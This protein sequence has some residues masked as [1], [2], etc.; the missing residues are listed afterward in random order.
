L[1]NYFFRPKNDADRNLPVGFQFGLAEEY[2][3]WILPLLPHNVE[4][5]HIDPIYYLPLGVNVINTSVLV[6]N[7]L[8]TVKKV[9]CI[10]AIPQLHPYQNVTLDCSIISVSPYNNYWNEFS[11]SDPIAM[12]DPHVF[13]RISSLDAVL[14]LV[15][16]NEFKVHEY[17]DDIVEATFKGYF[18]SRA[19]DNNTQF[20][21]TI[22][23]D[24][25]MDSPPYPVLS[26]ENIKLIILTHGLKEPKDRFTREL[27]KRTIHTGFGRSSV[28]TP[29]TQSGTPGTAPPQMQ[30]NNIVLHPMVKITKK[31]L[32][33]DPITELNRLLA[34]LKNQ[35]SLSV[36]TSL[37][38]LPTIEGADCPETP[39]HQIGAVI[40][41]D[42]NKDRVEE[43]NFDDVKGEK[44]DRSLIKS[45]RFH[46]DDSRSLI[47]QLSERSK[48]DS[49]M[50]SSRKP[51]LMDDEDDFR[52]TMDVI[53]ESEDLNMKDF[54]TMK[55]GLKR[56]QEVADTLLIENEHQSI[57]LQSSIAVFY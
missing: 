53:I 2:S 1:L 13:I 57:A 18:Y 52:E 47:M 35:N 32:T 45:S 54:Q 29:A 20:I 38:V 23:D 3:H 36:H 55:I 39:T 4:I 10:S 25:D 28:N 8:Q 26:T 19:K 50:A 14:D 34:K 24:G 49:T 17:S 15:N 31:E 22:Y 7:Q 11:M 51:M 44:T 16:T 40:D 6:R 33:T 30:I 21:E 9:N 12:K 46:R 42:I 41:V 5:I 56:L 37:G 48:Q 43:L 27:L